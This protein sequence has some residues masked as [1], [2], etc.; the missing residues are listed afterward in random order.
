M[1]FSELVAE[2][3]ILTKRPDQLPRIES[4]VR[5]ATLKAHQA[6]FYHNDMMEV[7]VQFSEPRFIQTFEPGAIIPRFRKAKYIRDF[8]VSPDGQV[9]A[10]QNFYENIQVENSLDAYGL[11]RTNVF[12]MAGKVLQLRAAKPI[13]IVL[14][15]CYLHPVI[16]EEG[17]NSWIAKE[18]PY[19]IIYEAVRAVFN[20][21]GFT[22]Q[23]NTY[24]RMTQEIYREIFISSVDTAPT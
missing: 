21:I 20:G 2:V 7:P 9:G 10:T 18:F 13:N 3:I 14:F 23:A 17:Y 11:T 19:A 1:N 15:G 6:D 22:E 8:Y 12:Y 24:A 4:A 5:A 16:T